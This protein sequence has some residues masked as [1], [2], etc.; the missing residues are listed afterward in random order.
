[1]LFAEWIKKSGKTRTAV[2]S[3]IGVSPSLITQLC[4]GSVWPGKEVA[5]R[6]QA[7]TEG[8]VTPNDFMSSADPSPSEPDEA[9]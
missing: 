4:D 1:M 7:V 5:G 2:A 9:A 3:E 6:I 8:Q